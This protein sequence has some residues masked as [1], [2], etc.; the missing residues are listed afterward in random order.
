MTTK[1]KPDVMSQYKYL[2][3]IHLLRKNTKYS[4]VLIACRSADYVF[5]IILLYCLIKYYGITNRTSFVTT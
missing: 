5:D 4:R 3:S 2:S 1:F